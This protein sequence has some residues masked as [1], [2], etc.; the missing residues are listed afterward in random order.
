VQSVLAAILAWGLTVGLVK[1]MHALAGALAGV[2][3]SIGGTAVF[4][5]HT[6]IVALA[7]CA[8]LLLALRLFRRALPT[9]AAVGVLAL[10]LAA[11]GMA[12]AVSGGRVGIELGVWLYDLM[13]MA[14][15]LFFGRA[16]A[17]D[18]LRAELEEPG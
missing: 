9:A 3:P 11:I 14:F 16:I 8:G 2:L 17:R 18:R 12:L 1:M 4:W 15:G 6:A 7:A 13:P 10:A 5:G